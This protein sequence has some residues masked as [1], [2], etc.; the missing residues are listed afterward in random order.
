[1]KEAEGQV[2]VIPM[3]RA[4]EDQSRVIEKIKELQ[5]AILSRRKGSL[6]PDSTRDIAAARKERSSNL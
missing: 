6:L 1:M 3:S 2:V 4:P 5:A